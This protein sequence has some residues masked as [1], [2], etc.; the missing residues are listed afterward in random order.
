MDDHKEDQQVTLIQTQGIVY[1]QFFTFLVDIGRTHSLI[2]SRVVANYKLT[3]KNIE[4]PYR[5]QMDNFSKKW[6]SWALNQCNM[7]LGGR[8][9]IIYFLE[10]A[11]TLLRGYNGIR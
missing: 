4:D 8:K 10:L 1:G 9:N 2:S 11:A 6:V 7:D 3:T 5:L